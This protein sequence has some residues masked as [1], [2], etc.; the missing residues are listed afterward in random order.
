MK[1]PGGFQESTGAG[2]QIELPY[3]RDVSGKLYSM[4]SYVMSVSY[5]VLLHFILVKIAIL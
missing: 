1:L 5:V 4:N 3:V 2:A